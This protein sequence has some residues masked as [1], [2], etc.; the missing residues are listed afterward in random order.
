MQCGA[1]W[2]EGGSVEL[3]GGVRLQHRTIMQ[4]LYEI[5]RVCG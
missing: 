5:G 1:R 2:Q 3:Y 4:N